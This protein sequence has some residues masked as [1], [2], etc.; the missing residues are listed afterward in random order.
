MLT[1]TRNRVL[2][3]AV[4]ALLG[5]GCKKKVPDLTGLSQQEATEQLADSKLK[6]GTVTTVVGK[7][8]PGTVVDQDPKPGSKAEKEARVAVVLEQGGAAATP[9]A[10]GMMTTPAS[11]P[12]TPA[13]TATTPAAPTADFVSVPDLTGKTIEQAA[14]ALMAVGLSVGEKRHEILDLPAGQIFKTSPAKNTQVAPGS[15]V[16]LYV[17]SDSHALIP[18]VKGKSQGEAE[19]LLRSAGFTIGKVNYVPEAGTPGQVVRSEPGAP[20]GAPRGTSVDI[21]VRQETVLVPRVTGLKTEQAKIRLYEKGLVP[22]IR[23][24]KAPA[25]TP[26]TD[27]D[28][29]IAQL[30]E[31]NKAVGK[32]SEVAVVVRA[33]AEQP[34]LRF[35]IAGVSAVIVTPPPAASNRCISGFVWREAFPGDLV[36]VTPQIRAQAAMDNA[37]AASRYQ[38]GGGPYGRQ[39]CRQGFVWREANARD[40]VCVSPA[41]RAQAARDNSMAA[42]RRAGG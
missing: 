8:K 17:A 7:G 19:H 25:G 29:V 39:T 16:E 3:I 31:E 11:T 32:G 23:Q 4:I 5:T 6:L 33:S 38:P 9:A 13:S 1:N 22:V 42:S 21:F 24:E 20:A 28:V 37:Q 2:C 40:R 12:V 15:P 35:P 34:W 27:L 26:A 10:G 41:T 18:E 36:C 30:Q 14:A